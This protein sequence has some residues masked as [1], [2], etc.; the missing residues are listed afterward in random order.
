M[1]PASRFLT[2]ISA[3]LVSQSAVADAPENSD[4]MGQDCVVLLHGLARTK[5]SLWVMDL[6]LEAAG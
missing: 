5:S 1:R 3:L 2:I 4:A 6:A